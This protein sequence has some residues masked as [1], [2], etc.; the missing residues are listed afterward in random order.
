MNVMVVDDEYGIRSHLASMIRGFGDL[1]VREAANGLEALA[2]MEESPA[3]IVLTDIRMP[4]MDGMELLRRSRA[5]F[6]ETWFIVLSNF[7]EFELAQQALVY[8]ARNYLLKA[9][10]TPDQVEEEVR[11][12]V[13]HHEKSK[14]S[15]AGLNPNEWL[16][17]QNSLFSERL[18][19]HVQNAELLRRAE[20]FHVPVFLEGRF[21]APSKFAAMEIERFS[22]WTRSKFGGQAD[23]AV[24]AL[25]NVLRETVKRWN[26]SNELFHLGQNRF[27]LLDLGETDDAGHAR[28]IAEARE[29]AQHYLGLAASFLIHC[30]FAGLDGFFER[31]LAARG[32]MDLFFYETDACVMDAREA[33]N[34]AADLDLFSFFESVEGGG[35]GGLQASGLP[36]LVETYFEL[37]RNLRRPSSS[38]QS[39]VRT[40]IRFIEKGGYAVPSAL[41]S[42]IDRLSACRL[43]DFKEPFARWLREMGGVSRQREEIAKALAFIHER[44]A[45]K[46]TLED[47]C[48]HVNLSRSHL[49]KLFKDRQGVSV[50]EY[51]EAFRLRQARLLLRTTR[52]PIAEIAERVGVDDVFYFSKLYKKHFGI[53]PSKDRE[54]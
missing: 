44:Y 49:S 51:L 28:K 8:G 32:Q 22:D 19:G 6:P 36:G 47:I 29:A 46:I 42:D 35:D 25:S 18:E 12:A 3:E 48:G 15:A 37:L 50:M 26:G 41:K 54:I 17:V 39:D 7:A 52:R 43:S 14:D 5:R 11:R 53:N 23:L 30:D 27:V 31:V 10:I 33:R 40:L 24:Y 4:V 2:Q 38:A 1:N 45:E 16:M 34:P 20:R 9:T 21:D 13:L